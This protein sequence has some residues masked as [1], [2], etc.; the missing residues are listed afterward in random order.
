MLKLLVF[1]ICNENE[2]GNESLFRSWGM[3]N[4]KVIGCQTKNQNNKK[5]TM[6][7]FGVALW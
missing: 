7:S 2:S 3:D 1:N 4:V 5:C 6:S